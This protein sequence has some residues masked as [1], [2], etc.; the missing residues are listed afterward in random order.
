MPNEFIQW[1][2]R[3]AWVE[4]HAPEGVRAE[5]LKYRTED[6]E[7]RYFHKPEITEEQLRKRMVDY[8]NAWN[9]QYLGGDSESVQRIA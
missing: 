3:N 4:G 8:V 6:G 9:A 7:W 2:E 5:R 1:L